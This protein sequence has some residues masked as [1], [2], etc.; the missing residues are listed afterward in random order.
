MKPEVRSRHSRPLTPA[1]SVGLS[2]VRVAVVRS[3][4]VPRSVRAVGGAGTVRYALRLRSSALI[5]VVRGLCPLTDPA[6]MAVEGHGE[7]SDFTGGF[8]PR[9]HSVSCCSSKA[10]RVLGAPRLGV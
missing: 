5:R 8:A 4:G 10:R 7:T 9:T 1:P 6:G 2:W 3:L